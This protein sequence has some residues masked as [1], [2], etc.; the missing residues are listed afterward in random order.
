MCY[1]T[2]AADTANNHLISHTQSMQKNSLHLLSLKN[3]KDDFFIFLLKVIEEEKLAVPNVKSI[4]A[5]VPNLH[6]LVRQTC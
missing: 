3:I 5:Y 2:A 4:I 1:A 6:Y